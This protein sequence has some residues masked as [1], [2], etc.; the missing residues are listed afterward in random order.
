[1]KIVDANHVFFSKRSIDEQIKN[2]TQEQIENFKNSDP[3]G[4]KLVTSI[5][6][7]MER[8]KQ[9]INS[10]E[11]NNID[12]VLLMKREKLENEDI[13][14]IHAKFPEKF[15]G[16]IPFI[17]PEIDKD[18]EIMEEWAKRGAVSVHLF[19]SQWKDYTLSSPELLP[20]FKKIAELNFNPIIKVGVIKG[21]SSL[22]PS[23]PLEI[24]PWLANK[25]L[26]SLKFI[27][28]HFG[29]GY[30]REILMMGYAHRERILVDTSGSNDW[31]FWSPWTD[32]TQVFTKA[33]TALSSSNV[34]FGTD[35]NVKLLREDVIS[36]QL[37]ILQDLITKKVITEEDREKILFQ[38]A[39]DLFNLKL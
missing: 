26:N 7:P 27:F 31:I 33:I 3:V 1:M 4:Y 32:L 11:Q 20:Y 29:A 37:G 23:N 34:I 24:R 28:T 19:P 30:L 35:S 2:L 22:W 14:E 8:A 10:M 16:V 15:P 39:V 17:N 18:P 25:D 6:E 36:R 38:N 12:Y 5:P 21:D 13:F 9:I